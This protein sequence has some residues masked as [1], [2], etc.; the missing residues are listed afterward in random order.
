[1]KKLTLIKTKRIFFLL[2]EGYGLVINDCKD[3]E[4]ETFLP[5][6]LLEML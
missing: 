6:M 1:M 2:G 4:D 3:I 5:K